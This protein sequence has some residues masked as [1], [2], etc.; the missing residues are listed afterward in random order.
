[1]ATVVAERMRSLTSQCQNSALCCFAENIARPLL[2]GKTSYKVVSLKIANP[3]L[4]LSYNKGE[5]GAERRRE[6]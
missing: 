4:S 3:L 2:R 6:G 1:M 5:S